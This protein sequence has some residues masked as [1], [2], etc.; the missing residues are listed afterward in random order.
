[1][2]DR[3][4]SLGVYSALYRDGAQLKLKITGPVQTERH[5][6]DNLQSAAHGFNLTHKKKEKK[7]GCPQQSAQR[8]E[9]DITC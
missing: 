1:M 8:T 5:H 9:K 6:T 3:T 4:G 2:K 7:K